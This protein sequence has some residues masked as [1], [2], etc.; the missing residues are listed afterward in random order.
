MFIFNTLKVKGRGRK[1][2]RDELFGIKK[3]KKPSSK[4]KQQPPSNPPSLQRGPLS[5]SLPITI[6]RHLLSSLKQ[7]PKLVAERSASLKTSLLLTKAEMKTEL[8]PLPRTSGVS[9]LKVTSGPMQPVGLSPSHV[10]SVSPGSCSHEP[11]GSEEEASRHE[12][13]VVSDG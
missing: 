8:S 10:P 4:T 5:L 6:D 2:S 13:S 11:R 12:E 3:D 9:L 7:E 1:V